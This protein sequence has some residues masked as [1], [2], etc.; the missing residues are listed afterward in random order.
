MRAVSGTGVGLFL[1]SLLCGAVSLREED[2]EGGGFACVTGRTLARV[3][4][5]IDSAFCPDLLLNAWATLLHY[6][7]ANCG[8][9]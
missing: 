7:L 9:G 1:S 6:N 4:Q 3:L 2:R 5:V 8:V